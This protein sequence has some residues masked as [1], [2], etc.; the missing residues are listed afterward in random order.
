M[1]QAWHV[2]PFGEMRCA[3]RILV[4]KPEGKR[5]FWRCKLRREDNIKMY[6]DLKVQQNTF[7][8]VY[9]LYFTLR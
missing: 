8:V 6:Y 7:I 4:R 9:L 5:L 1:A 2:T 3:Y